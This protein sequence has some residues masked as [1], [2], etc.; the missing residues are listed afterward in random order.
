MVV[1]CAAKHKLK[2]NHSVI[3]NEQM[4]VRSNAVHALQ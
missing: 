1:W 3:F 4:N 2:K